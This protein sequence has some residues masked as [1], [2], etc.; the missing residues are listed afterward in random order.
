MPK[1]TKKVAEKRDKNFTLWVTGTEMNRV[2]TAVDLFSGRVGVETTVSQWLSGVV[3][4][5]VAEEEKKGKR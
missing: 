3:M 1:P 4:R 5:A 2:K